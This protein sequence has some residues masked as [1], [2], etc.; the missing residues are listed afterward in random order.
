MIRAGYVKQAAKDFFTDSDRKLS[1]SY[2]SNRGVHVAFHLFFN[3]YMLARTEL[4]VTN[5][6]NKI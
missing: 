1:L 4:N 3:R 6:L 2:Y 5:K